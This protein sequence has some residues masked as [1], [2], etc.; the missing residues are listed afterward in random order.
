M[1]TTL[2][3][4]EHIKFSAAFHLYEHLF[5]PSTK[6]EFEKEARFY[7]SFLQPNAL[8]FDI[9]ANDGHK[10][11]VFVQIADKVI[12]CEPDIKNY[13]TLSVRFRNN[14]KVIIENVAVGN[15]EGLRKMYQHHA[16][17]AFN[18]LNHKFKTIAEADELN[19][20][21][22]KIR[23]IDE[24][25]VTTTTLDQLIK[26]YGKPFF[27]KV[28][29]EGFE[30]EVL[31]GLS[32]PIPYMT[33]ECLLPEFKQELTEIFDLIYRLSAKAQF[34]IAIHEQLIFTSFCFLDEIKKKIDR[35]NEPHFELVI[36]M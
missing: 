14:K 12:C 34:N 9:G 27:I 21:S 17:S 22:E 29:V 4:Y 7:T 19:K 2:G 8:I 20:W 10:T 15:C 18:T 28:D 24:L 11:A 3:V 36:K 13:R 31:K 6:R 25:K 26:K 35:L 1:L 16:G 5:K 23:Y 32:T 30:L 33:L